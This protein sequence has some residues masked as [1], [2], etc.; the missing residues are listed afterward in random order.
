MAWRFMQHLQLPTSR[1]F[2]TNQGL[3]RF[4]STTSSVYITKRDI[5]KAVAIKEK[6]FDQEIKNKETFLEL[7]QVF[8]SKEYRTGHNEFVYAALNHMEAYGV[9]DD[10]E[11]YKQI[12]DVMPKGKMMAT[13]VWL[14]DF[15]Y[16][17]KHQ[18]TIVDVL[19]KMEMRRKNS[20]NRACFKKVATNLIFNVG[21]R[22]DR[23]MFPLLVSI[24]GKK[25]SPTLKYLRMMYWMPKLRHISPW[26]APEQLL[27]DQK[28]A[29]EWAVKRI[30]SVDV[31]SE[32]TVFQVNFLRF[33]PG[34]FSITIIFY[35]YDL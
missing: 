34:Y 7:L 20:I 26:P 3:C 8:K 32:I 6:Y 25:S 22:P 33:C 15:Q 13:N 10:L 27:T 16:F 28:K 21:I 17:P 31:E 5:K 1:S 29:S 2:L 11:C 23:E 4:I 9:E 18:Q 14:A 30:C 19:C 12:I 35:V 24:F